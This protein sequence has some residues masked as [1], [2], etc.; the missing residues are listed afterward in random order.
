V[1]SENGS[2]LEKPSATEQSKYD[3]LAFANFDIAQVIQNGKLLL[4][5]AGKEYDLDLSDLDPAERLALQRKNLATNLGLMTSQFMDGNAVE[6]EEFASA[7]LVTWLSKYV[8][9]E[10]NDLF[11]VDL[12]DESDISAPKV[13]QEQ[14]PTPAAIGGS[15]PPMLSPGT[16]NEAD[17]EGLSAR[18]RNK[19]KRR[20]KTD[21][22][23]KGKDKYV[24]RDRSIV[25]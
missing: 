1:K 9:N 14:P 12:V 17:M 4:G 21:L 13:K 20:A 10:C 22:K 24:P 23:F 16:P 3:R 19:L 8:A 11:V 15:K 25:Q 18:E 2:S 6:L 7:D 5:S